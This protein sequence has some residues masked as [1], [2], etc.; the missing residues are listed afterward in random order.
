M[1]KWRLVWREGILPLLSPDSLQALLAALV[2]DDPRVIQGATTM[3]PPLEC[4]QDWPVEAACGIGF[5]G[6]QGNGLK[7]VAE[8]EEYIMWVCF[9]VDQKLGELAACRSFLNWFDETPRDQMRIELIA[10]IN[11]ALQRLTLVKKFNVE[12][13]LTMRSPCGEKRNVKTKGN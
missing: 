12:G 7:T 10:E 11:L 3:P 4:I 5:C 13:A 8:V 6:W 2:N 1:E 9:E